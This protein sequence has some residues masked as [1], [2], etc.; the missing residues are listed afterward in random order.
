MYLPSDFEESDLATIAGLIS[1]FPLATIVAHTKDGLI[2]NPIPLLQIGADVLVGHVAASNPMHQILQDGQDVMAIFNGAQ[3]YISP[4]WYPSKANTHRQVPTWN[5]EVAQM[6][7][8]I[9]FLR[10]DK[11]KRG[12]VG[13]LTKEFETR[14]NGSSAWKMADAPKEFI[15]TKLAEIVAFQIKVTRVVAKSELSQNKSAED[16]SSVAVHISGQGQNRLATRMSDKLL[17]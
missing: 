6:H 3:S 16:V 5:Y 14:T 4:N 11:S 17:E 10:D 1:N 15:S 8:S 12:G 7:G 13:R 2:A 9:T